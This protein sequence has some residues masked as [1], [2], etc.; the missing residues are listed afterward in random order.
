MAGAG[1]AR[2]LADTGGMAIDALE[3]RERASHAAALIC[4]SYGSPVPA[5]RAHRLR[6]PSTEGSA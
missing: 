4:L 5:P 6:T 2:F 3:R 1:C